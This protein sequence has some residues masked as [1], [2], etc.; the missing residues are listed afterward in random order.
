MRK[1]FNSQ[2]GLLH[3]ILRLRK[4]FLVCQVPHIDYNAL[5]V[6]EGYFISQETDYSN[7]FNVFCLYYFIRLLSMLCFALI[8]VVLVEHEV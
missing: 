5:L 8:F 1:F 4:T 2:L 7:G 3:F 6:V